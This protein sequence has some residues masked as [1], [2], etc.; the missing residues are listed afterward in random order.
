MRWRLRLPT[1]QNESLKL[2]TKSLPEHTPK[3]ANS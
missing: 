1:K 3:E 2:T